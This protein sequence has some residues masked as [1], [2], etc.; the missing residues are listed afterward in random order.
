MIN[1]PEGLKGLKGLSALTADERKTWF[2]DMTARGKIDKSTSLMQANMMYVNQQFINRFGEDLF[3]KMDYN[4]RKEFYETDVYKEAVMDKYSGGDKWK[5]LITPMTT[6]DGLKKLYNSTDILTQEEMDNYKKQVESHSVYDKENPGELNPNITKGQKIS[7]IFSRGLDDGQP[8]LDFDFKGMSDAIRASKLE[9]RQQKVDALLEK[10]KSGVELTSSEKKFIEKNQLSESQLKL[11]EDV[12][13]S[14]ISR[15]AKEQGL[16]NLGY[17]TKEQIDERINRK[18]QEQIDII[19]KFH[20]KERSAIL[21]NTDVNLAIN[22]Y[23]KSDVFK[24]MSDEDARNELYELLA[25]TKDGMQGS[26]YFQQ[27]ANV[28]YYAGKNGSDGSIAPELKS[29]LSSPDR[30]KRALAQYEVYK[31]MYGEGNAIALMDEFIHDEITKNQSLYSKY[32]DIK[33]GTYAKAAGY[34]GQALTGEMLPIMAWALSPEEYEEFMTGSVSDKLPFLVNPIYW[35]GVDQFSAYSP[36]EIDY[37]RSHGNVSR[38][39]T[40]YRQDGEMTFEQFCGEAMK[41]RGYMLPGVALTLLTRGKGGKFLTVAETMLGA[42]SLGSGYSIGT[43]EQIHSA[44]RAKIDDEFNAEAGDFMEAWMAQNSQAMSSEYLKSIG[45][46]SEDRITNV[47]ERDF[48]H[49]LNEAAKEAYFEEHPDRREA[50]D[51][52]NRE[53]D[54]TAMEGMMWDYG[55]EFA[56]MSVMNATLRSYMMSSGTRKFLNSGY[57]NIVADAE[58]NLSQE[59]SKGKQI[60]ISLGKNVYGGFASNYMDDVTVGFGKGIGEGGFND[61]LLMSKGPNGYIQA[62]DYMTDFLSSMLNGMDAAG[63][64]LYD[65]QSW[66]D[67]AIGGVGGIMAP[68]INFAQIGID[69]AR[70]MS[71]R[72]RISLAKEITGREDITADNYK[73]A[74][75]EAPMSVKLSRYFINGALNSIA[76]ADSKYRRTEEAIKELS[77]KF[78][79]L[80]DRINALG[81]LMNVEKAMSA[82]RSIEN[83]KTLK[84]SQALMSIIELQ[85]AAKDPLMSQLIKYDKFLEDTQKIADGEIPSEMVDEFLH[86]Q[87][88][89]ELL[90]RGE[91]GIQEAYSTLQKNAKDFLKINERYNSILSD[92]NKK[93]HWKNLTPGAKTQY[94]FMQAQQLLW[95]DRVSAMEEAL[96]GSPRK[97]KDMNNFNH[98]AEF[99]T[100]EKL[101]KG[102]RDIETDINDTNVT[103]GLLNSII[104]NLEDEALDSNKPED[105]RNAIKKEILKYKYLVK[106]NEGSVVDL[107]SKLA[108][109]KGL[110]PLYKE[111]ELQILS[112]EEI[113]NLNPAQR[114]KMINNIQDYS[115][116]QREEISKAVAKYSD[117]FDTTNGNF[118]Q[119]IRD[120]GIVFERMQGNDRAI[121][122][123]DSNPVVASMYESV[124]ENNKSRME[125]RAKYE[126]LKRDTFDR[127]DEVIESNQSQS[128]LIG[129]TKVQENITSTLVTHQKGY[130]DENTGMTVNTYIS[131]D[132][133]EDYIEEHP[134][135]EPLLKDFLEIT[136]IKDS[137]LGIAADISANKEDTKNVLVM[138]NQAV[139]SALTAEE[140]YQNLIDASLRRPSKGEDAIKLAA[141]QVALHNVLDQYDYAHSL[142]N[143]TK[144]LSRHQKKKAK[145]D[146]ARR[147]QRAAEKK[148][149]EQQAIEEAKKEDARK[150][151]EKKAKENAEKR[152]AQQEAAAALS[153]DASKGIII[154]NTNEMEGEDPD[155]PKKPVT[156]EVPK[157]D[158]PEEV[159]AEKPVAAEETEA[160]TEDN[161][162]VYVSPEGEVTV[163]NEGAFQ[164]FG[165]VADLRRKGI[166]KETIADEN[167]IQSEDEDG[168]ST[169]IPTGSQTSLI[170][171]YAV[172]SYDPAEILAPEKR[173]LTKRRGANEGDSMNQLFDWLN[174]QNIDLQN[175]VDR[176]VSAIMAKDPSAK[177]MFMK[178]RNTE[179]ASS[180]S[181]HTFLVTPLTEAVKSVHNS[182]R[183]GVISVDGQDYLIVGIAG[184]SPRNTNQATEFQ[185][186]NSRVNYESNKHFHNNQSAYYIHPTIST[187]IAQYYSGKIARSVDGKVAGNRRLSEILADKESNPLNLKM[188]K[189]GWIM[190]T[191]SS[192]KTVGVDGENVYMPSGENSGGTFLAVPI[193][194]GKYKPVKINQTRIVD[195]DP[196]STLGKVVDNLLEQLVSNDYKTRDKAIRQLA[197]LV[198]LSKG[199]TIGSLKVDTKDIHIGNEG[200]NMLVIESPE[201]DRPV[202]IYCDPGNTLAAKQELID[203]LSTGNFLVSLSPRNLGT[204]QS[205]KLLDEAG[206]LTTDAAILAPV[207]TS[208]SIY[209]VKFDDMGFG[210]A[211]KGVEVSFT[212]SGT[213]NTA[214]IQT[215]SFKLG[216]TT[217]IL[218]DNIWYKNG[219]T[220]DIHTQEYMDLYYNKKFENS[221]PIKTIGTTNYFLADPATKK[222]IAIDTNTKKATEVTPGVELSQSAI[223]T[224]INESIERARKEELARNIEI[225][226]E[227]E[228]Q[229]G[230]DPEIV[231]ENPNVSDTTNDMV[232]QNLGLNNP[233]TPHIEP[234]IAVPI[235]EDTTETK[236]KVKTG[237]KTL[238]DYQ[239]EKLEGNPDKN[240]FAT[241]ENV[242]RNRD[243]IKKL[244]DIFKEKGWAANS[245]NEMRDYIEREL[246]LPIDN[247]SDVDT[248]LETLKNCR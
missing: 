25:P 55:I 86:T 22:N 56:R 246:G 62:T 229:R 44:N 172:P 8:E 6:L 175:I 15:E 69:G 167:V 206:A 220:V 13:N 59:I 209:P 233:E 217:Y 130:Y 245:R 9:K 35:N 117:E 152:K 226:A 195:L 188:S 235:T 101:E 61:W 159:V 155:A 211:N 107:Q 31:D 115:Y 51:Y 85:E 80:R 162:D 232:L 204:A 27:F 47:E 81:N 54:R 154:D 74:M 153:A 106:V 122:F 169:T 123:V 185:K 50:Y 91:E 198:A 124:L 203:A 1:E 127:I 197:P 104:S 126:K 208:F 71:E 196:N 165:S 205:V 164:D 119:T 97:F 128:M 135:S 53:A 212:P 11:I 219:N 151:A 92:I 186:V 222:I 60:A 132:L 168:N 89:E 163:V 207:N 161:S 236:P 230:S 83:A 19:D 200:N 52:A 140:A 17:L 73:A 214:P 39:N 67:G 243:N 93:E 216:S 184:F 121:R 116:K 191:D 160:P 239:K 210:T 70:R 41:M 5:S 244:R 129:P 224:Y 42:N 171:G 238:E 146:Y 33:R 225:S 64:A 38:N 183:G 240:N 40:V 148:A 2:N 110:R 133:I 90:A 87:G 149:K 48:L 24:N 174:S 12:K 4:Q 190:I 113:M 179:N 43:Y 66:I 248:F 78:L 138:I 102:I 37:I 75:K 120:A 199:K 234:V 137:I 166:D 125:T 202:R 108:D 72:G 201:F 228:E 94:A 147:K 3:N 32:M 77:P 118:M 79:E 95:E 114:A 45:K 112:A 88:N 111:G 177:I 221:K 156:P 16:T 100:A 157:V 49:K 82:A 7:G 242:F 173:N 139:E 143:S 36:E 84:D 136:K 10:Q 213:R 29:F 145:E 30:I 181:N 68:G 99:P 46:T 227:E 23:V 144:A 247:I 18:E 63:Q 218:K 105:Q 237:V 131:S 176:E 193:G 142:A 76:D 28:G 34:V 141:T 103:I 178:A 187:E 192:Y 14:E 231:G 26:V 96:T 189:L 182:D 215:D 65:K 109:Y 98:I 58:G 170:N 134:E 241:F 150:E 158:T 21:K 194:N 20:T 57:N 223:D 180:L